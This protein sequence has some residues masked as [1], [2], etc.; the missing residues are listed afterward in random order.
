M[1]KGITSTG[2][3]YEITKDALN[4]YELIEELTELESNPLLLTSVVRKIFGKE[5]TNNLKDHVRKDNGTVPV[6][7]MEAEVIEIIKNSGEETKK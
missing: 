5:Q 3:K 2:F 6:E 7:K 1:I 4:N